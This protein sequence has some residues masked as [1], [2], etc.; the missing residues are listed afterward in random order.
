MSRGKED[1]LTLGQFEHE[2]LMAVYR[3]RGE[4]Y[5]VSVQ[6]E[7]KSRLGK[8]PALGTISVALARLERRGLAESELEEATA[9]RRG[10][11][12]RLYR[13]TG[14][15]ARALNQVHAMHRKLWEGL[16]RVPLQKGEEG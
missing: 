5:T 10:R 9:G 6:D 7:L 11:P 16:E 3:L 12:K 8:N 14:L 15:G 2:V 1:P 4:A 13:L